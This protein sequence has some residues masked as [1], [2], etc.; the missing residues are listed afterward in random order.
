VGAGFDCPGWSGLDFDVGPLD[1]SQDRCDGLGATITLYRIYLLRARG[2]DDVIEDEQLAPIN[3]LMYMPGPFNRRRST[4]EETSRD[5]IAEIDT[6]RA[7]ARR[8]T[9]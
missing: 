6:F 2:L 3:D 7:D 1:Q 8:A 9:G 5:S 4:N